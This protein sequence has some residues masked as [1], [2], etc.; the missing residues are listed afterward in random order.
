MKKRKTEAKIVLPADEARDLAIK[1][2]EQGVPTPEML[3]YHVL[4]SAYGALHPEV[5]AFERRPKLGQAGTRRV[6]DDE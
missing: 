2:A 5:I 3:G 4:R 6:A 1:A